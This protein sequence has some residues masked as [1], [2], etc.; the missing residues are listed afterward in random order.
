MAAEIEVKS[1]GKKGPGVKKGK[2]TVHQGRSDPH[3]GPRV[4][5]DYLLYVHHD[6]EFTDRDEA[7]YAG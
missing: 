1:G 5:L 4:S 6:A 2:E 7:G 3:G